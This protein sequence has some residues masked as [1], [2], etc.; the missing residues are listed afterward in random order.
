MPDTSPTPSFSPTPMIG[1]QAPDFSCRTTLGQC[2]LSDFTGRWL[3]FF[4]HPADFTPVCTSEFLAFAKAAPAFAA[5]NCDLLA[6]SV[7]SLFS[8]LAWVRTIKTQFNVEIPFPIVE[9]PSMVIAKAYGMLQPEAGHSGTVRACF[10]IDPQGIIRLTLWYPTSIGR[11]VAEILRSL[12]ALQMADTHNV[13]VPEAWQPGDEIILPP[14]VNAH[15]IEQWL[16]RTGTIEVT[17]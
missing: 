4:S 1:D 2:K 12:Q 14:E 13:L 9:D 7:D 16:I 5:L 15:H 8:H 11:N 6:L 3:V 10:I 17:K